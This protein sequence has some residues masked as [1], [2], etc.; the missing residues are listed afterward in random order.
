MA[1]KPNSCK[2]NNQKQ[3]IN[4]D[5]KN[6]A[7]SL[8]TNEVVSRYGSANAEFI[9]GYTGIDNEIG[10]KLSKGLKDI[11][12]HKLNPE[13]IDQNIK[14]QAG[15]SAEVALTSKDNAEL[16]IKGSKT[17]VSRSDDLLQY[18][19]NHN[20]VDRVQVIDGQIISGTETQVKFVGNRNKLF[21]DI[22]KTDGKFARYRGIKLE[23]PSEQYEGAVKYC[24]AEAINL[25]KNA[26]K[27]EENGKLEVAKQ[28]REQAD[29][30]DELSKNIKDTGMT[31]NEAISYRMNPLKNT[32]K[33]IAKTSH[34]AGLEGAKYGVLIGGSISIL[35][36]IFS[37]AQGEKKLDEVALDVTK[38]TAFSGA[39]GYSSAAVG[40]AIKSGMQQSSKKALQNISNTSVPTLVVS[41][42]L[43][44]GTSIKRYFNNEINGLE[45]LEEIGE[46]G[47]GMLSAGMMS[48]LG[49][50]AI[51]IPF[52]GA[53]IGGMIGYSLSSIFYKAVLDSGKMAKLAENRYKEIKYV[54]E[55]LRE[56]IEIE[57][58][59]FLKFIEKEFLVINKEVNLL[60]DSI[61][62][63]D[64]DIDTFA[65]QINQISNLLG[66]E[67]QFKNQSEFNQFMGNK[68]KI[69]KL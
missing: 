4:N 6:T 46:K 65:N 57:K 23:I 49:Q 7:I 61:E 37:V 45:F 31:T 60:L 42:C 20:V 67:L 16:I 8:S 41:V 51:P 50:I 9:K 19:K 15:Y 1:S 54:Q 62:K 2:L 64:Y 25:R 26:I 47:S 27:A 56:Q 39:L 55:Y 63:S 69:L 59:I 18:G 43:S 3:E 36:N 32:I 52:L 53:A 40:S 24:K 68:N 5:I 14:Q 30:Y 34:R 28:L 38:D 33:D 11:S 13:Y 17:R 44:L 10:I 58:D 12:K 48:A 21:K 22:T 35:Q 29:N 66:K